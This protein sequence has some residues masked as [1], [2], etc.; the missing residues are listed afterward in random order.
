MEQ[1]RSLSG[2]VERGCDGLGQVEVLRLEGRVWSGLMLGWVRGLRLGHGSGAEDRAWAWRGR[3]VLGRGKLFWG[4]M[5]LPF[6]CRPVCYIFIFLAT[7]AS[8]RFL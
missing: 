3:G 8:I 6:A 7:N 2:A 1:G 5:L 4:E